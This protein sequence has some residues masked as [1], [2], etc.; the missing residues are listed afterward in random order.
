M[1]MVIIRRNPRVRRRKVLRATFFF[2]FF[3]AVCFLVFLGLSFP[4]VFY[5]VIDQENVAVTGYRGKMSSITI[6]STFAGVP[7]T[8]IDAQAF[9]ND[10]Y[11]KSVKIGSTIQWIDDEAFKGCVNLKTVELAEGLLDI[12]PSAFADCVSLSAIAFPSTLAS[13]HDDAFTGCTGLV[14]VT[15]S[16]GL[17]EIGERAFFGCSSISSL[18]FPASLEGI[19][20]NAF[21][22]CT[23][24]SAL[25]FSAS[26]DASYRIL[27]EA[28]KGCTG[29]VS[30]T[31]PNSCMQI[32]EGVF[33]G[34]SSL[35]T[36]SLPFAGNAV[37]IS[38]PDGLFGYVFGTEEYAGSVPAVQTTQY[39]GEVTNYLP[40]TLR[41]VRLTG[42]SML[43][44]GCFSGCDRLETVTLN[45]TLYWIHPNAFL[46]CTNL[47][48]R[49]HAASLPP[50][51]E[52]TWNPS[53]CPVV[54]GVVD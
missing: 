2:L 28:F 3:A 25:S 6:R 51:W 15:F 30:A 17:E 12:Y 39:L 35:V 31:I 29:L 16:E 7:V 43:V 27:D 52:A 50:G 49:S 45:D 5:R 44:W 19:Y 18:A 9:K 13:I 42:A 38:T 36:L 22:G 4:K 34:C 14:S 37:W 8:F 41:H 20:Q 46:G 40:A 26:E 32:G 33:S 11:L 47:T 48:I 53:G 54:F 24:L 23:G 10:V 21:E 1:P